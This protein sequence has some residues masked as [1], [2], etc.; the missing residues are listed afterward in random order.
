[1]VSLKKK[2][3][4]TLS[5][6][7]IKGVAHIG[8]LKAITE[9]GIKIDYITG[10]SA[11]AIVGAL[12]AGGYSWEVILDFFLKTSIF[13]LS[14][15]ARRKPGFIDTIKFENDLRLYF[16]D[17]SFEKLNIPLAITATEIESGNLK[18]FDSGELIC[19]ILAS[20]A[21][22]GVFT[23][24]DID[25]FFYF[26]GGVIDDF[27]VEY[28]AEKCDYIIGSYANPLSEMTVDSLKYSY[29]VLHRAYEINLHHHVHN[30]FN[31]CDVFICPQ[32]LS[33]YGTFSMRSGKKIFEIGYTEAKKQLEKIDF[34]SL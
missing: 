2:I 33:Q 1:M 8:T 24:I 14:R 20:S 34:D 30:K 4:L 17:N 21:F 7:G 32:E 3:G 28:L 10:T 26:D 25:G 29:Q 23:P 12:Y 31:D 5:G 27:P 16:P 13:N 6:G 19:P 15:F 11:G 18:V 9:A 22:P